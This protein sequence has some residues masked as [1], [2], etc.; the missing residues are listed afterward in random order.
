MKTIIIISLTLGFIA[1]WGNDKAKE[2]YYGRGNFFE[3]TIPP[4]AIALIIYA[5][6]QSYY[7]GFIAIIEILLGT[8]IGGKINRFIKRLKNR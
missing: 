8:F 4:L 7:I 6:S 5:F 1:G 2:N 3:N